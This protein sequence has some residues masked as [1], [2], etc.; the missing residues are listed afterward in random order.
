MQNCLKEI[1]MMINDEFNILGLT[2]EEAYKVLP[3]NIKT[4]RVTKK[5]DIYYCMTCDL[6]YYVRFSLLYWIQK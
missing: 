4:I 1:E 5:G 2:V 3:S 6:S